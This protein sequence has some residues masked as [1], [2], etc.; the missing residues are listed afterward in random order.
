MRHRS[1]STSGAQSCILSLGNWTSDSQCQ[2][3]RNAI[4]ETY[5]TTSVTDE[6]MDDVITPNFQKLSKLGHIICSPM[7]KTTTVIRDQPCAVVKKHLC[8]SD[9]MFT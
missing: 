2:N 4:N 5:L 7:T 1:R 3:Y 8:Y 9:T 6:G